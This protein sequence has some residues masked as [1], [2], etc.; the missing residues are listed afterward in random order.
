MYAIVILPKIYSYRVASSSQTWSSKFFLIILLLDL[1]FFFFQHN[2]VLFELFIILPTHRPKERQSD[3]KLN[4]GITFYLIIA[5]WSCSLRDRW[6][7]FGCSWWLLALCAR[8]IDRQ[9]TPEEGV[10]NDRVLGVH[11]EIQ[12][13]QDRIMEQS[14]ILGVGWDMY[15]CVFQKHA[16]SEVQTLPSKMRFSLSSIIITIMEKQR[17]LKQRNAQNGSKSAN[18]KSQTITFLKRKLLFPK[19]SA[20]IIDSSEKRKRQSAFELQ[21]LRVFWKRKSDS[22]DATSQQTLIVKS[23]HDLLNKKKCRIL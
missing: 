23:R 9:Q 1:S 5:R 4:R 12:T 14:G 22:W 6:C 18:H 21:N 19:R 7:L 8:F 11:H 13:Q 17:T 3:N 20:K 2:S 10:R 15:V 16:N